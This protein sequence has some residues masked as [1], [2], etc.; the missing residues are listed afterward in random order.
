[1]GEIFSSTEASDNKKQ[2]ALSRDQMVDIDMKMEN[3][4]KNKADSKPKKELKK[5]T[6]GE[7]HKENV[8]EE[9]DS[10]KPLKPDLQN[11]K[12]NK[13]FIKL[14]DLGTIKLNATFRFEKKSLEFELS[15]GFGALTVIYTF[16]TSIANVSDIPFRFKSLVVTDA[17]ETQ[18]AI[19]DRQI[20]NLVRQGIMQF[21]KVIGSV[22]IIGNPVN[23]VSKLGSGVYEFFSEPVKGLIVGPREFV[24]GIRKG[25][26]SVT[27]NTITAGFDS[28]SKI[29]GS[30]YSILKSISGQR[31]AY[32]RKPRNCTEG[33]YNGT[34]GGATEIYEGVTGVVSKP[35]QGAKTQGVLGCIKG[36]GKGICG[37]I[38]S[39]LTCTLRTC[40]AY[41]QGISSTATAIRKGNYLLHGWFRYPRYINNR[42]ILEPYD[43]MYSEAKSIILKIRKGKYAKETLVFVAEYP[44]YR[45]FE[46][47][48]KV[49]IL[50]VTDNYVFFWRD[51]KTIQY[52]ASIKDID[53]VKT[54]VG[55]E[56]VRLKH[57]IYHTYI[58]TKNNKNH[59]VETVSRY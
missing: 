13:I 25:V 33:F 20:K 48:N 38:V 14:I 29:S 40:T 15:K 10:D 11:I 32:Q 31:Y 35:Y 34:V 36:T 27:T 49:G 19:I 26:I 50:I 43:E 24:G 6:L 52:K 3:K 16:I 56:D 47:M 8:W 46:R 5:L 12:T 59:V 37:I 21:Y 41:S 58:L 17:F 44:I 30:W 57:P 54:Y 51:G 7:L 18:E 55:G 45:K 2:E 22:D 53:E 9:L 4:S 23:F 28:A 42:N 39:P 1:M